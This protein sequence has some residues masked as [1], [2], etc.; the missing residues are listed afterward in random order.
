LGADP[1]R[2]AGI[3]AFRIIAVV[4]VSQV[5]V[6]IGAFSVPALLPVFIAQWALSNTDAGWIISAF[7]AAYTLSVPVLVSL[8]D[9]IDPK[10][11]YLGSAAFTAI[12]AIGYA[13]LADGLWSAMFFRALAGIGWAGTYMPGLKALSDFV[14]GPRQSRAVALHAASVGVSGAL[15]FVIAGAVASNFG[16]RW[17]IGLGGVGAVLAF[18]VMATALPGRAPVRSGPRAL[19]D[20]RPVLRNRSAL[21]YSLGYMVHTWEMNTFRAW[22]VTFLVFSAAYSGGGPNWAAPVAVATALALAGIWASVSGNEIAIRIGRRKFI[23]IV[24]FA[25][26]AMA[27]TIGFASVLSYEIVAVLCIVY[28]VLIWADSASLTAGA[29][30]SA[31]P[32]QRGA[33]LAVHSTLGYAGGFAG[34]LVAGFILDSADGGTLAWGLAFASVAAVL[35]IGPLALFILRPKDLPGDRPGAL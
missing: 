16:W 25:S 33:T 29:V 1:H 4:C 23:L 31:L 9:R 34:P 17:G 35:T 11:I 21:A 15:S 5:L 27:A 20:F 32:G 10:K 24:M 7:Y 12:A 8:T 2:P 19:L 6:Q 3:S 13:T 30:G 22:V 28:G 14:E 18:I 26:M